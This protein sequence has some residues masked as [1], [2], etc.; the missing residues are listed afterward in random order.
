MQILKYLAQFFAYSLFQISKK[1]TYKSYHIFFLI[2]FFKYLKSTL[3]NPS[4]VFC[5]LS[6]SNIK[7]VYL[8]I[9]KNLAQ[10]F[11]YS[12]FQIFKKAYLQIWKYSFHT[13]NNFK[14]N[15]PHK[16]NHTNN[17]H[18]THYKHKAEY[19]I[20]ACIPKITIKNFLLFYKKNL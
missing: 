9:L 19:I 11:A 5:L 15:N 14:G 6:F 18:K 13:D 17:F 12:L 4:A 10:F 20:T 7:Q 2:P 8:Q 16:N 1:Y 3:T